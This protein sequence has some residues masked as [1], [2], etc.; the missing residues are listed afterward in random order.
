MEEKRQWWSDDWWNDDWWGYKSSSEPTFAPTETAPPTLFPTLGPTS[1]PTMEPTTSV[2]TLTPSSFL[3]STPTSF[4]TIVPSTIDQVDY[5]SAFTISTM[6]E[7]AVLII[8]IV[9]IIGI[10]FDIR[11]LYRRLPVHKQLLPTIATVNKKNAHNS[12]T[13]RWNISED[14]IKKFASS[15]KTSHGNENEKITSHENQNGKI[16]FLEGDKFV[17]LSKQDCSHDDVELHEDGVSADGNRH[18]YHVDEYEDGNE[19]MRRYSL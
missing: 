4:P 3:T 19:L 18:L 15:L 1:L 17:S 11:K 12:S 10:A 2:P 14:D 16:R 7:Y 5:K 9:M 13:S 6:I 8:I